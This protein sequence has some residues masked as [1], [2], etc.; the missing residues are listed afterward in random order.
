MQACIHPLFLRK[1]I[2]SLFLVKNTNPKT[3]LD[4]SHRYAHLKIVSIYIYIQAAPQVLGAR[5]L[6]VNG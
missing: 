4:L 5:F 1:L 2:F 6:K 3:W